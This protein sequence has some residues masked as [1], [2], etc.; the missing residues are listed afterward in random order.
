MT[1]T[2]GQTSE[3]LREFPIKFYC[4]ELN[5]E[6]TALQKEHLQTRP[7]TSGRPVPTFKP[8]CPV[9]GQSD[10]IVMED[11]GIWGQCEYNG[12]GTRLINS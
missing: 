12:C 6:L 11:N 3:E 1:Q 9:C 5:L 2:R 4:P 7:L 10:F 8:L